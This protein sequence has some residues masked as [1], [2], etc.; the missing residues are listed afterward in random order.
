MFSEVKIWRKA[1]LYFIFKVNGASITFYP[2]EFFTV[3]NYMNETW[4]TSWGYQTMKEMQDANIPVE[5]VP[6]FKQYLIDSLRNLP[7]NAD[8]I[9]DKKSLLVDISNT[10]KKYPS[11]LGLENVMSDFLNSEDSPVLLDSAYEMYIDSAFHALGNVNKEAKQAL[12]S[13]SSKQSDHKKEQ[14]ANAYW[15]LFET[16]SK[17]G[18]IEGMIDPDNLTVDTN[19]YVDDEEQQNNENS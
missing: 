12:L 6:N 17:K 13:L 3:V 4:F 11:L 10:I 14:I 9:Y 16:L 7:N 2:K 5:K 19:T 8:T 18:V 15:Y 1:S